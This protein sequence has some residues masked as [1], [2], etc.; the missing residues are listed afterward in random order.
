MAAATVSTAAVASAAMATPAGVG[1][2]AAIV[3]GAV[4]VSA[5]GCAG[6]IGRIA[7]AEE[8]A[9]RAAGG[10]GVALEGTFFSF[11]GQQQ[12]EQRAERESE[13]QNDFESGFHRIGRK[14]IFAPTSRDG[15]DESGE[16]I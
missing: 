12:K 9:I 3:A 11:D 15:Q 14:R 2:G 6:R 8:S 4:S 10:F 13:K 5:V 1:A 16:Q 7:A